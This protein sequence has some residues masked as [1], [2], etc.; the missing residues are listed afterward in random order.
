MC[1]LSTPALSVNAFGG[2]PWQ[3]VVKTLP[4]NHRVPDQSLVRELRSHVP[5]GQKK[6]QNINRSNIAT[7]SIK[8]YFF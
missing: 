6:P 4:S 1:L 8:T 7:N 3:P 2:H 5:L